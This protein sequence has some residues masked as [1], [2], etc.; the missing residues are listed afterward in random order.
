MAWSEYIIMETNLKYEL[1]RV[2]G[3][4]RIVRIQRN[5]TR[6]I[7]N[8]ERWC[9]WLE[10]SDNKY[11]I[12]TMVLIQLNVSRTYEEERTVTCYSG[13]GVGAYSTGGAE[14]STEGTV[15][16]QLVALTS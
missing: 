3:G 2:T 7:A 12:E 16:R 13:G 1:R 15:I 6:N 8:L 4:N 14:A 5:H 10:Q 9:Q 11:I